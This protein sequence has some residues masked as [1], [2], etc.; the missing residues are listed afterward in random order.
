MACVPPPPP[1]FHHHHHPC[2]S[3]TLV[4]QVQAPL[5]LRGL[6]LEDVRSLLT[7]SLPF[8]PGLVPFMDQVV[9]YTRSL[10][11]AIVGLC[12]LRIDVALSEIGVVPRSA[13]PVQTPY[14][15]QASYS[16]VSLPQALLPPPPPTPTPPQPQP[17]SCTHTLTLYALW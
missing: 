15:G 11:G 8:G 2:L 17:P 1:F 9:A 6:C 7:A 12:Q 16:V 5:V 13:P 14:V 4:L 10:P 3:R